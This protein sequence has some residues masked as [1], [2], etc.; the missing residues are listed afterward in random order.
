M[1]VL[2]LTVNSL[3]K[4]E[5]YYNGKF[6]HILIRIQHISLMSIIYIFYTTCSLANQTVVPNIPGFQG[7]KR[8]IQYL[9]SLPHKPIFY[10]SNSYDGSN[11][12]RL[13]WSG[14]QVEYH[15]TQNF[16]ECHKDADHDIII[17][18][19]RSVSGIMH[20]LLG[21]SV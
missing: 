14:N 4:A 10:P 21:V 5:M 3:H 15:T 2:P 12:V 11:F 18:I 13:T 16:L 7:I 6:G 1:A 17:N 8:C 19:I 20:T 9:S